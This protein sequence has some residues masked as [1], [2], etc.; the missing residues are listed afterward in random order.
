M[1]YAA[2]LA[3]GARLQD[4][5]AAIGDNYDAAEKA[6]KAFESTDGFQGLKDG[7]GRAVA[8]QIRDEVRFLKDWEREMNPVADAID[9]AIGSFRGTAPSPKPSEKGA[10]G[11]TKTR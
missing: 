4:E 9:N 6:A 11:K 3:R 10:A 2:E 1:V 7:I 8:E 5:R